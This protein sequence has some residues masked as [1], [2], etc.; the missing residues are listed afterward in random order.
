MKLLKNTFLMRSRED[1][2]LL[3]TE[4]NNGIRYYS[5][6]RDVI[7]AEILRRLDSSDY[8]LGAKCLLTNSLQGVVKLLQDMQSTHRT[9]RKTTNLVSIVYSSDSGSDSEMWIVCDFLHLYNILLKNTVN[10][11]IICAK[12]L[13]LGKIQCYKC[14]V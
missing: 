5:T 3:E 4:A 2:E 1:I 8:N 10:S 12:F 11:I 7:E 9:M 6:Q 13:I 14:N